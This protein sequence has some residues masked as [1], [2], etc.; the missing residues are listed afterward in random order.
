MRQGRWW[1]LFC[2]FAFRAARPRSAP[3]QPPPLQPLLR[4]LRGREI[5][6]LARG[7]ELTGRL[8]F[9]DQVNV[10]LIG[11]GGRVTVVP[12]ERVTSVRF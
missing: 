6:I 9:V 2:Q 10:T 5:G 11:P 1:F 3:V 12:L 4:S 8:L 7:R